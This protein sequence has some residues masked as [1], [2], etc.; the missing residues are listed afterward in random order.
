MSFVEYGE[1]I[2]E[3]DIS[4]VFLGHE[5]MFPIKVQHGAQTQTRYGVIRHSTDLIGKKYG[6][7]VTCSKGGWVYILHPTPELWTVN[8]PHRTQILYSTDISMILMMLELKPGSIVCESGTG[9]GSLSHSII[10]TIAPTGHLYT[11]EFHQQRAE[12]ATEEFIAHRVA[13]LVTVKNQDVCKDGF[14]VVGVADA[15]FLDIPSPWEAIVHA[16]AAIKQGGGRLCSFSPCIEQVQRTCLALSECGFEEI[17][18]ME[19]L[20]RVYDVRTVSLPVPDLGSEPPG[21]Q[22]ATV[23]YKSAVTPKEMAGHTGYLTFA[24]KSLL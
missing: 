10:R 6:S 22:Q 16:K 1:Y 2:Q 24:T 14:G 11:V 19:V 7:K 4:I 3:G 13:H 18:T 8:L 20:L 12:K 23:T 5:S 17:S 9:S 15:V 21:S